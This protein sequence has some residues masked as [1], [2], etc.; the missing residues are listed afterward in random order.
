V[1]GKTE[2]RPIYIFGAKIPS[3]T[4]SF[5]KALGVPLEPQKPGVTHHFIGDLGTHLMHVVPSP[6]PPGILGIAFAMLIPSIHIAVMR[7]CTDGHIAAADAI[8]VRE[9]P[10]GNT[11]SNIQ[12]TRDT[13][14]EDID[15]HERSVGTGKTVRQITRH[16]L[17][18]DP[19]NRTVLLVENQQIPARR[20][21]HH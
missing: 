14:L 16:T 15:K 2:N 18:K 8:D 19:D 17:L 3:R 1:A 9:T 12:I 6:D 4:A 21:E 13:L 7:L 10:V 5:Y 20:P 11:K